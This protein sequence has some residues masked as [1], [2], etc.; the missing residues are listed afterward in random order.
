MTTDN[1]LGGCQTIIV[2][3]EEENKV[4]DPG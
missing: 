1:F 2:N 3:K 4:S